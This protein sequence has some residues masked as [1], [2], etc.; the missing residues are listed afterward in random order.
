MKLSD[1]LGY[2]LRSIGQFLVSEL[3]GLI[4]TTPNE[5]DTFEDVLKTYEGG[6]KIPADPSLEKI[7]KKIPF[8]L[9][10]IV[11]ETDGAGLAKFPMPK[12]IEGTKS[13][14]NKN[15][16]FINTSM[17]FDHISTRI[18]LGDKSA[19]RTDAEFAREML[20]GVNPVSIR[21]LKVYAFISLKCN[22]IFYFE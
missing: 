18:S 13:I 1:F 20:A 21:L 15:L 2:G 6:I 12:V 16:Y 11:S 10:K 3:Q 22:F 7:R 14:T 5:F 8:E 19:W 17:F 4:D 9:L